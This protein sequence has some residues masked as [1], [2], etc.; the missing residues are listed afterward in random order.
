MGVEG[1]W[2]WDWEGQ[3]F[4]VR[5]GGNAGIWDFPLVRSLEVWITLLSW[6]VFVQVVAFSKHP[7]L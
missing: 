1:G 4:A 5:K 3:D 2:D 6:S 7:M